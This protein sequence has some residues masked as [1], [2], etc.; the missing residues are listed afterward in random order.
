[1]AVNVAAMSFLIHQNPQIFIASYQP[2]KKRSH[3]VRT[4]NL[5]AEDWYRA[6]LLLK[7]YHRQKSDAKKATSFLSKDQS[8][9]TPQAIKY[10][11][12]KDIKGFDQIDTEKVEEDFDNRIPAEKIAAAYD[13][14]ATTKLPKMQ[15]L[16]DTASFAKFVKR[17]AAD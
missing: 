8:K 16:K 1:V 11:S 14:I 2:R 10:F 5:P 7:F 4:T 3:Y 15:N 13:E 6:Y 9:L 17:R 12:F